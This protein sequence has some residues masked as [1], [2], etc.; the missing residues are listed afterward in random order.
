MKQ[1]NKVEEKV[2]VQLEVTE[3]QI[4]DMIRTLNFSYTHLSFY[5]ERR[6]KEGVNE[7]MLRLLD[8]NSDK[9]QDLIFFFIN[10][11]DQLKGK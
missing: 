2:Q 11:L 9:L 5:Y 3:D 10:I 1:K 4:N 7:N 8:N 6:R